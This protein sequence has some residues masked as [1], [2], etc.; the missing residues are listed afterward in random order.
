MKRRSH[1]IYTDTELNSVDVVYLNIYQS[2]ISMAMKMHGYIRTWG[3]NTSKSTNFIKS[4]R[5]INLAFKPSQLYVD[6]VYNVIQET[7]VCI[8]R[9]N[10][11]KVARDYAA[12]SAIQKAPVTWYACLFL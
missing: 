6:T 10:K 3:L 7:Y 2:F 1:V 5:L 8:R 12:V 11:T 4:K 9:C